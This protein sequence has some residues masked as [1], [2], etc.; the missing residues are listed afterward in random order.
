MTDAGRRWGELLFSPL[1]RRA[2]SFTFLQA[3]A[4]ALGSVVVALPG[5]YFIGNYN[6]KGRTFIR[7]LLILPFVLPGILTVLGF[8]IFYGRNG[9]L[10]SLMA[11]MGFS[12]RVSSIYGIFGIIM[13]HIFYNFPLAARIMGESWEGLDPVYAEAASVLGSGRWDRFRRMTVPL[14]LP[15][16]SHAFLSAFIYSFL[17]FTVVLVFGG[18]A[19]RTFEV[20]IYIF[21]NQRLDFQTMQMVATSQLV[22]LAGMIALFNRGGKSR[23]SLARKVRP[24]PTLTWR[25]RP[26]VFVGAILY[27]ALI[28][29]FFGG[30]LISVVLRSFRERGLAHGRW[31]LENY[32][33]LLSQGFQHLIGWNFVSVV[34]QSVLLAIGA[35]TV[36]VL[37]AYFLVRARRNLPLDRWDTTAQAPLGISLLTF[38]LGLFALVGHLLPPVGL[39]L[40]THVFMGFPIVYVLLRLARRSMGTAPLEA[41]AILGASPYQRWRTIEW[42]LMAASLGMGFA[43]A[44]AFSLGDLSAILTL[45]EGTVMTLPLATYRLI[46]QYRFPQ[47]LALGTVFMLCALAVFIT[48]D[49]WGRFRSLS[50]R[51]GRGDA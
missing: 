42:P 37:A 5:A 35:G 34:L 47:A 45:G 48:I 11:N 6:F 24:L 22:I 18:Y 12:W 19:Y 39:V 28:A 23:Y 9:I 38:A 2:L 31:T 50:R 14:L 36:C 15:A 8:I 1:F 26:K 21:A 32:Q 3:L 49:R 16:L 4:S 43:Y 44:A 17:S 33:S 10:N 25:R 41:A 13:A 46:G 40:W 27:S 51:E 7:S 30:P 29:F 20:L